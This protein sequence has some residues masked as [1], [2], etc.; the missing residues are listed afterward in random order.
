MGEPSIR[1]VEAMTYF[2][3]F[4]YVVLFN[5]VLLSA[6]II[7]HE[8]GH[9]VAGTM[10]NDCT[11]FIVLFDMEYYGPYTILECPL[12]INTTFLYL[13]AFLLVV[14]FALL[15]L[16]LKE[17]AECNFFFVVVGMGIYLAAI[18]ISSVTQLAVAEY[19][20]IVIGLL[21]FLF[22]EYKLTDDLFNRFSERL[23]FIKLTEKSKV[24]A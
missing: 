1:T 15:F 10:Y 8:A 5:M 24:H 13:S 4:V 22:G 7:L 2:K 6:A 11:G 20:S 9:F 14:P 12:E 3:I 19:A 17:F 16:F 21:I 23:Y 18:D